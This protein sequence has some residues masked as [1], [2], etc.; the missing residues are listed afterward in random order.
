LSAALGALNAF[1]FWWGALLARGLVVLADLDKRR[2]AAVALPLWALTA[3]L[4][5]LL[6]PR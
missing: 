4:R 6:H 5:F 2:A 3:A 1:V